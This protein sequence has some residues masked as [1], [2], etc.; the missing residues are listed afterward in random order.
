MKKKFKI[1]LCLTCLIATCLCVCACT[2][3]TKVDEYKNKGYKIS[4]VYDVNGGKYLDREG[5]SLIDM[6]NPSD[7]QK[8]AN[9]TVHIKL[10][11]P[12]D[13]RRPVSAGS[14]SI[15]A[16]KTGSFLVGWYKNRV[17]VTND[18]GKVIDENGVELEEVNGSYV[19]PDTKAAA[20][21]MYSYSGRWDFE[22]DTLDYS[23]SD[24]EV[25]LT[26]YAGWVQN[27]E[28]NYYFKIDDEWVLSDTVTR[29]NYIT[30]YKE[31]STTSDRNTIWLPDWKDG[32]MNYSYQY[33]DGTPY[34][35]P[36][37]NAGTELSNGTVLKQGKT[38]LT[39]YLDSDCTEE[40]TDGK[41][42][43]SGQLDYEKA[44]AVNRVQNVYI[45]VEDGIKYKIETA[46]QLYDN[47]DPAGEYELLNDLDFEDINWPVSFSTGTFTGKMFG[48]NGREIHVKNVSVKHSSTSS[49][50]GGLFGELAAGSEVTGIKFDNVKFDLANTGTRLSGT[51]FGTFAGY[52]DDNAKVENIS[53]YGE[54]RI[55]TITL[56]SDYSFNLVANGNR[57]GV[58]AGN[59]KL[60]VYGENLFSFYRYTVKVDTVTV[61]EDK[62]IL[63]DL[64]T[65]EKMDQAEYE[66]EY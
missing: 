64:T 54:F 3:E 55:G 34:N 41:L 6:I 36:R 61:D 62:N 52:I 17:P 35:F 50:V 10:L 22:N 20:T 11:D 27:F 21:P 8:D 19:Y 1:I 65:S 26:L 16:T 37:L 46:E 29:F 5:I 58:T 49:L 18:N 13:D 28:F 12:H 47:A 48:T 32:A 25:T 44:T 30:T 40:I 38:F 2:S 51:S 33:S 15:Y 63:F 31:G 56:G 14:E 60:V 59:I 4:V 24:G 57:K 7:F 23:D 42:V 45:V 66:I 43:H 53:I 39:A 9:G